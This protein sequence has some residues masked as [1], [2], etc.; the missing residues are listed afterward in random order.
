MVC[1]LHGVDHHQ[2]EIRLL[3]QLEDGHSSCNRSKG[4]GKFRSEYLCGEQTKEINEASSEHVS[5][6][7]KCQL[8]ALSSLGAKL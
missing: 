4:Y 8:D 1:A 3:D 2:C 6:A 5:G 7:E